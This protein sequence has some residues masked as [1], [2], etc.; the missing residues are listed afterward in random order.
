MDG[1]IAANMAG[2]N[3]GT[4]PI[5][6]ISPYYL[7]IKKQGI[8]YPSVISATETK[9]PIKA[10]EYCNIFNGLKDRAVDGRVDTVQL[11]GQPSLFLCV[12]ESYVLAQ[13]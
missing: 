13:N 3:A 7:N 2:K 10:S 6:D 8:P 11:Q 12:Q 5:V 4:K 9:N 1:N